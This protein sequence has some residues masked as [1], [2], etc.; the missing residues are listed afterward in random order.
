MKKKLIIHLGYPKTGSTFMQNYIFHNCE[1]YLN[2]KNKILFDDIFFTINSL[3]K[4]IF[5]KKLNFY[6]QK[7]SEINFKKQN[8]ISNENLSAIFQGN[9][10][11]FRYKIK[12]LYELF[13]HTGLEVSFLLIKRKIDEHLRSIFV[14]YNYNLLHFSKKNY[15]MDYFITSTINNNSNQLIKKNLNTHYINSEIKKKFKN[16]KILILDMDNLFKKRVN[17]KKLSYLL[18][19]SSIKLE[20]IIKNK[21]SV[22]KSTFREGNWIFK[23]HLVRHISNF[24][25]NL[26]NFDADLFFLKNNFYKLYLLIKFKLFMVF[27]KF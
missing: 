3:S 16:S 27:K 25:Q 13:N 17:Y 24:F 9:Y 5:K 2:I 4:N 14:E 22:N 11:D 21:K 7:I 1:N 18:A 6:K 12:C 8:I 15:S 19:M 26:I 20:N 23:F 10:F